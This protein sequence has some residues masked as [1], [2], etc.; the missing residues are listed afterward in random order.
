MTTKEQTQKQTITDNVKETALKVKQKIVEVIDENGNGEID[1]ED[2]IIKGLKTPGI[3]IDRITFLQQQLTKKYPQEVIDKVIATSPMKAHIPLSEI[4]KIANSVISFERNCVSGISAALGMPGGVAM[5]ATLP[6]DLLQYY[7]Y[8]LRAT[9]KLLY[10]YGFPQIDVKEKGSKFD[11]ATMNTLILCFGIMYSVNGANNGIR[12]MAGALAKGIEK[13]I[14]REAITKG[15]L[16]KIAKKV[17][18]VFGV[19]LT[20]KVV[21]DFFKAALPVVGG[22]IGGGLTYLSFKPCCDKLKAT[23]RDT[24]LSN[25]DYKPIYDEEY[26]YSFF[27]ESTE[28]EDKAK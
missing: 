25:P 10:L 8:L 11:D 28:N 15:T 24:I 2:V 13:K 5:V 27:E 20:K 12:A 14:L 26:E 9:Q 18:Q 4:D 22:V 21:S 23:L 1:L 19:K 6:A 16:F 17:V 3:K 7:G